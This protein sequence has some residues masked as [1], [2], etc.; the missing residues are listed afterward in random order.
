MENVEKWI[1]SI[2]ME[3]IIMRRSYSEQ[4]KFDY[5][6]ECRTSGQ[7]YVLSISKAG[8]CFIRDCG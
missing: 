5:V 3:V 6:M 1:I 8:Y 7:G 2:H 4:E